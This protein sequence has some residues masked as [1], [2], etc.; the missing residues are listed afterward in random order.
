MVFAVAVLFVILPEPDFVATGIG[1]VWMVW[2]WHRAVR[3]LRAMAQAPHLSATLVTKEWTGGQYGAWNCVVDVTK[4][5]GTV[6]SLPIV[7]RRRPPLKFTVARLPYGEL[8]RVSKSS[9]LGVVD[10]FVFAVVFSA[11]GLAGTGFAEW[12]EVWLG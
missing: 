7:L 10:W 1:T 2:S 5:D 8:V 12:A 3:R 4:D 6:Q 11:F 9:Q